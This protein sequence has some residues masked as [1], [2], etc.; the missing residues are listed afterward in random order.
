MLRIYQRHIQE[1]SQISSPGASIQE[2]G[3]TSKIVLFYLPF[4]VSV[5]LSPFFPMNYQ[6]TTPEGNVITLSSLQSDVSKIESEL[7]NHIVGQDKGDGITQSPLI[8]HG[9]I[10]HFLL[11]YLQRLRGRFLMFAAIAWRLATAKNTYPNYSYTVQSS[12]HLEPHLRHHISPSWL[13]VTRRLKYYF[14]Y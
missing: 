10:S 6:D 7:P 9:C 12:L 1:H 2:K 13:A 11:I 14:I 8:I 4:F 3:A 5:W